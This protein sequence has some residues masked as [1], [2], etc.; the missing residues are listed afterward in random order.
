MTCGGGVPIE[1]DGHHIGGFGVSGASEQQDEEIVKQAL[2][3]FQQ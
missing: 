2:S 1:V 3:V